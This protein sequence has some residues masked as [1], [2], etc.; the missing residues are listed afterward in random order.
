MAELTII[1]GPNGAGKTS[2]VRYLFYRKYIGKGIP[3]INPDEIKAI[4]DISDFEASKKALS[5]R[6]M[7]LSKG[8]SFAIETT[9]SG[10]SERRLLFE[11]KD[12]GYSVRMYFIT[13]EN[14]QDCIDRV[15]NRVIDRGHNIEDKDIL[16]RFIRSHT[17][18]LD[19]LSLLNKIFVFENSL[20]RRRLIFASSNLNLL[21][22]SK[23]YNSQFLQELV[24]SFDFIE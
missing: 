11:A 19:I 23:S 3:V 13:L 24:N 9:F 12:L 7:L 1:A 10:N 16:R 22:I 20:I 8:Q 2:L 21:K 18:F 5:E 14:P 15:K 4:G 6:S 17:N